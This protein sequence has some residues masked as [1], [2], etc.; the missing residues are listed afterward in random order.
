MCFSCGHAITMFTGL[1]FGLVLFIGTLAVSQSEECPNGF[2]RISNSCYFI[3]NGTKELFSWSEARN[4]C[5]RLHPVADLLEIYDQFTQDSLNV[6]ISLVTW[7]VWIGLQSRVTQSGDGS[8]YK[9]IPSNRSV[10]YSNWAP[11]AFVYLGTSPKPQCAFLSTSSLRVGAWDHSDCE[12]TRI[13]FG[14]EVPLNS[15]SSLNSTTLLESAQPVWTKENNADGQ[16]CYL[17]VCYRLFQNFP[18]ELSFEDAKQVCGNTTVALPRN[19]LELI[20]LRDR[21]AYASRSTRA[22]IG[23]EVTNTQDQLQF[24]RSPSVTSWLAA[25]IHRSHPVFLIPSTNQSEVFCLQVHVNSTLSTSPFLAV[26]CVGD[27]DEEVEEE[28]EDAPSVAAFCAAPESSPPGTCPGGG[29]SGNGVEWHAFGDKCFAVM[30]DCEGDAVPASLKTPELDTFATWLLPPNLRSDDEVLIGGIVNTTSP[31]TIT[32][33]DGSVSGG[34]NRLK[35]SFLQNPAS[36]NGLCLAIEPGSGCTS[37]KLQAHDTTTSSSVLLNEPMCPEDY[38]PHHRND[39]SVTCYRVVLGGARSHGHDWR[40]AERACRAVALSRDHNVWWR[41]NLAS[42]PDEETSDDVVSLLQ[43]NDSTVGVW[44]QTNSLPPHMMK[45]SEFVWIGL[46]TSEDKLFWN[47]W[48][49][50]STGNPTF[51]TSRTRQNQS[52]FSDSS[53]YFFDYGTC[54]ALHLLSGFW[55]SLRCTLDLG[56]ICQATMTSDN[57]IDGDVDHFDIPNC[58]ISPNSQNVGPYVETGFI[59]AP[60]F[61]CVVPGFTYFNGQ[62]FRAFHDKFMTFAEAQFYCHEIGSPYS[63]NGNAGLAVLRSEA[64][65]LFVASQLSRLPQLPASPGIYGRGTAKYDRLEVI[66][67]RYHWIGLF[68]YRHAFHSVN[69]RV[70]CYIAHELNRPLTSSAEGPLCVSITG[71]PD[72]EHFGSLT[73]D[74]GCN[75]SLPFVCSFEPLST[76]LTTKPSASVC[77]KGYATHNIATGNQ[78]YRFIGDWTGTYKEA[79]AM[80]AQTAAGARLAALTSP[81][82]VAWLRAHLPSDHT[83]AGMLPWESVPHWIG[84]KLQAH[85]ESSWRWVNGLPVTHTRWS[86]QPTDVVTV[87]TDTCFAFAKSISMTS[88]EVDMVAVNCSRRLSPLCEADPLVEPPISLSEPDESY[89]AADQHDYTGRLAK[90]ASGKVCIRWDLISPTNT[91]EMDALQR[92]FHNATLAAVAAAL[93][94]NASTDI[95]LHSP[96]F[97]P[98]FS[99]VCN[100]CRNPAGLRDHA[101]CYINVDKWEFCTLPPPSIPSSHPSIST[102]PMHT[103]TLAFSVLLSIVVIFLGIFFLFPLCLLLIFCLHRK[104]RRGWV[105]TSPVQEILLRR[106]PLSWRRQWSRA[107]SQSCLLADNVSYSAGTVQEDRNRDPAV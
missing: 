26:P 21:L 77:P 85:D 54:I 101:F 80:C 68:H 53:G 6:F 76:R 15:L 70:P 1:T 34:F 59:H 87:A 9:W 72:T 17:G 51:Y 28:E 19:P 62:C 98:V 64:D 24:P 23:V 84:L 55:Y 3:Y 104:S 102:S 58:L 39:G 90:S 36:K 61:D 94:V 32:W 46:S 7:P 31:L 60:D 96:A 13:G 45:P 12:K 29:D 33:L 99:S 47:N 107:A 93:E 66:W 83:A 100:W 95:N 71:V 89:S 69:E 73:F 106:L 42:L 86:S 79:A 65:Q 16:V 74:I 43:Q 25:A 49:D 81:F 92:A 105:S 27:G 44:D 35:P 5:K 8:S 30:R 56:Y 22:W 20:F 11:D 48:T 52:F 75:E 50:G 57:E 10:E 37:K 40:A 63:R 41:G 91:T 38:L 97:Q 103:S 78:C 18:L 14:C 82:T 4:Q 88:Y 2:F 67:R